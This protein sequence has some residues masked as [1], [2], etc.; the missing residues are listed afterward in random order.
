V[1]LVRTDSDTTLIIR[2]ATSRK[3]ELRGRLANAAA[4]SSA[5]P[6]TRHWPSL[7]LEDRRRASTTRL[8]TIPAIPAIQ[9][10]ENLHSHINA[11]PPWHPSLSGPRLASTSTGL[12]ATSPPFSGVWCSAAAALLLWYAILRRRFENHEQTLTIRS[13][14][15]VVPP[16][17]ERLGD[18]NRSAIPLTYPG[19]RKHRSRT[20]GGMKTCTN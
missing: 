1:C 13:Q 2:S 20:E 11:H 6:R 14:Q 15:A 12:R 5:L 18:P 10:R 8:S 16:L 19:K 17:R 4:I 3:L 7:R 9:P